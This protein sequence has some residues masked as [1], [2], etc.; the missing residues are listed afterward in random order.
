MVH[1]KELGGPR[2][3]KMIETEIEGNRAWIGRRLDK[4][5]PE[6]SGEEE[7]KILC[8]RHKLPRPYTQEETRLLLSKVVLVILER[9]H[10]QSY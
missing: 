3:R 1:N 5:F 6:D 10:N 8:R 7:N 4:D 9:V 2:V